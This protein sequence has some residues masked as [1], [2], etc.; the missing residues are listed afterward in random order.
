MLEML[1]IQNLVFTETHV[2]E[3]EDIVCGIPI[4][5]M[6]RG[7]RSYIENPLIIA[8]SAYYGEMETIAKNEGFYHIVSYERI[9]DM[10]FD[11]KE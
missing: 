4:I 2:R 11:R 3:A 9:K 8:S 7:L 1:E 6:G 10:I 5:E